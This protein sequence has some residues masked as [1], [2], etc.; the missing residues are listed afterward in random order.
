VN[1]IT[2]YIAGPFRGETP[3]LI[4]Q[5]IRHAECVALSVARL[6]AIPLCPHTMY[7]FYQDSLPDEFWLAA[8]REL[9]RRCDAIMLCRGW[10]NSA[11]SRRE[12]VLAEEIGI[13]VFY[14]DEEATKLSKWIARQASS[15]EIKPG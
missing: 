4:E 7:R 13:P 11:G 15:A 3:W 8:T 1:K 9:L 10:Q 14:Y 6:G 5:N 2:V 12:K